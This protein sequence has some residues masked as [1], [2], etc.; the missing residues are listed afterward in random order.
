MQW[1]AVHIR[2]AACRH[3]WS[4]QICPRSTCM[5]REQSRPA[6]T[7]HGIQL[8]PSRE[9]LMMSNAAVFDLPAFSINGLVSAQKW[10]PSRHCPGP[11]D[12]LMCNV[13]QGWAYGNC[14]GN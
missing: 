5:S 2:S 13:K 10:A 11:H 1:G 14:H 4:G 12:H 6:W 7:S 9:P 8:Q 3:V